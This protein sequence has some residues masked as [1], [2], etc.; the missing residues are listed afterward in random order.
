MKV[1]QPVR[2]EG[3][4]ISLENDRDLKALLD[5]EYTCYLFE[6][7]ASFRCTDEWLEHI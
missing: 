5:A 6:R 3:V 4:A 1:R 7:K 2:V